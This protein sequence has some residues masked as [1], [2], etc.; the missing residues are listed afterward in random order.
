MLHVCRDL[1]TLGNPV[2]LDCNRV[3]LYLLAIFSKSVLNYTQ[4]GNTNFDLTSSTFLKG[5]G[6][7]GTLNQGTGNEYA[8]APNGYTVSAADINRVLAIRS[9]ANPMVNSGL[10]RVTAV[11]T[12]N[13]WFILNYRSGDTPPAE[14]G[15]TWSLW[16]SEATAVNTN[17]NYTGNGT[18]GTYQGQ[19]SATQSRVILQS[20]H[21]SAYQ[22]R[23]TVEN[24]TDG[25]NFGPCPS[26]TIA[27][28]FGGNSSGDFSA[29]GQ[30]LHGALYFNTSDSNYKGTSV[31][32]S[33]FGTGQVRVYIWGDDSLG[34][35]ICMIR[36]SF[37]NG[38][39]FCGWGICEDEEQPLPSKDVQRLFT[40]GNYLTN[41]NDT[42]SWTIGPDYGHS[43]IG[44]GLGEEPVI[45]AFSTYYFAAG[46]DQSGGS[47]STP[48]G[49][50]SAGDNPYL[51]ATELQTVDV[52]VGT[53]DTPNATASQG[54][55]LNLEVRRLGRF[56][57]GRL[58]RNNFGDW[59]ISTDA[60]HSWF[61]TQD[62]IYMP[63]QGSILP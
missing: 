55:Y 17:F 32:P 48:R 29:A 22:V 21:S 1:L 12:A 63:W 54:Q 62:G 8:F 18:T 58:G 44:F 2:N 59:Q 24:S 34:S 4:I 3:C 43:L 36:N 38:N 37:G 42:I 10:F 5:S 13:N 16:V 25:G 45:G 53:W 26:V 57:F 11:D 51:A 49:E 7:G 61:H 39:S 28:G 30:V 56:P 31:G 15:L 52:V 27:P 50:T 46:V 23:F 35:V 40:F 19:G 33:P 47:N 6:S 9:T 41:A 14:I 20:P 60:T